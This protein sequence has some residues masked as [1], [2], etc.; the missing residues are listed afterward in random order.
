[1]IELNDIYTFLYASVAVLSSAIAIG[2]LRRRPA[3]AALPLGILM[4]GIAAWSVTIAVTWQVARFADQVFWIR[5]AALAVWVLPVGTIMLAADV[6]KVQDWFTAPRILLLAIT[7]FLFSNVQWINPGSLYDTAFVA[8]EVGPFVHYASV[9]GPLYWVSSALYFAVMGIGLAVLARHYIKSAGAER[10]QA[11]LL[12]FGGLLPFAGGLLTEA[13]VLPFPFEGLEFAP[14]AFLVTGAVWFV[15]IAGGSLLD[16]FPIACETLIDQMPDG[17]MVL[18]ADLR[19]LKANPAAL[20]VLGHADVIGKPARTVLKGIQGAA[21][22]L[23]ADTPAGDTLPCNVDGERRFVEL[24]VVPLPVN[25]GEGPAR[26][27]TLHDVTEDRRTRDRLE[28]ART[29]FD[30]A[31]D[32]IVILEQVQAGWRILEVNDACCQLIGRTR[33]DL[34]GTDAAQF[35]SDRHAAEFHL[36]IRESLARTGQWEGE[37][38]QTRG[39]GTE[40]PTWVSLSASQD[41]TEMR[42]LI[43]GSFSDITESKEAERL[44]HDATHDPLTGLANRG[45]LD[46]RLAR[47]IAQARRQGRALAVLFIDLDNFKNI[48]DTL[49]HARG[50][51]V[52][53][54]AGRR[55]ASALRGGDM[56]ARP[57]GDEFLVITDAK[58]PA[59]IE[60]EA[61]RLREGLAAPYRLNGEEVR[62]TA[63][64]GI[65]LYPSDGE[66]G[67]TLIQRADLAMYGAKRLGRDRI[68]FFSQQLQEGLDRRVQVEKELLEGLEHGRCFLR[69]DPQ[70]DLSTG[71]IIGAEALVNLRTEDGTVMSPAEFMSAAEYS[72]VVVALGDWALRRTCEEVGSLQVDS[73]VIAS[74]Q[75]SARHLRQLEPARLRDALRRCGTRSQSM[76]LGVTQTAFLGDPEEISARLQALRDHVGVRLLSSD[77][78]SGHRSAAFT[79][80]LPGGVV[81]LDRALVVRLPGDAEARALVQSTIALAKELEAVVVAEGPET[82]DQIR[83]LRDHECDAAQGYYFSYPVSAEELALL[84][85]GD[86]FALPR[87]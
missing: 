7:S 45:V 83:F 22:N 74:I 66:D 50:D 11:A 19:V 13:R 56:A 26:L 4:L 55:I 5:A 16:V 32:G 75:L 14:L 1:M 85:Q 39:D 38:W 87:A 44:R 70:V 58:T 37:V 61:R 54:E 63:S 23:E 47:A 86:P 24:A 78:G 69:Y 41:E 36:S 15:A 65:A 29:V 3:R 71:R 76:A 27:V 84:L 8:H 46:D 73:G 43:V 6:A 31:N 80:L 25:G 2:A 62:V 10:R 18:D 53:A 34:I 82:E 79:A 68:Q 52:L 81:K 77:F 35:R 28:L 12:V 51:E 33:E 60:A 49:G 42:T 59:M 40:F 67:G 30:T 21:A 17:V 48:N 20:G 72:D 57:G 64:V 9:P